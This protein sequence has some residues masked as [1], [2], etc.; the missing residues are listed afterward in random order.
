MVGQD[1]R[2]T[3]HGGVTSTMAHS[4]DSERMFSSPARSRAVSISKQMPAI[5]GL[6]SA[7]F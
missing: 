7:R 6:R 4:Q 3:A 2:G 1:D 5:K